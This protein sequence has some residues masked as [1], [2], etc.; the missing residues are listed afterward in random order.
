[1]N[2]VNLGRSLIV[3]GWRVDGRRQYIPYQKFKNEQ[4]SPMG[5]ESC[6]NVENIQGIEGGRGAGF[7]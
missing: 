1:M 7:G 2:N 3:K 5:H 6:Q 4:T